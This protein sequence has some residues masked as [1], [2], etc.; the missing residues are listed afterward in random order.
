MAEEVKKKRGRPKGSKNK[1]KKV[2]DKVNIIF[3]GVDI[4]SLTEE[5]LI[6]IKVDPPISKD[7]YLWLEELRK[8]GKFG[9]ANI[10]IVANP[11]DI[12]INSIKDV[13][14]WMQ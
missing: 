1:P 9:K 14:K 13:P 8:D 3:E 11:F 7:L 4:K 2:E 6:L 12:S 10:L 5:D